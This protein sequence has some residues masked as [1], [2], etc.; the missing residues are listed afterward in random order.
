[1][2]QHQINH[3]DPSPTLLRLTPIPSQILTLFY[4]G[5]PF[6]I[7]LD[8]GATVS[9]IKNSYVQ[10]HSIPIKPNNQLALLADDKTR[11]ASLGEV[12]ISLTRGPITARLRALVMEN[13][14][15]DCFGGTTF[16]HDND[17]QPRIKSRQIKI[18][19]K[20]VL[21]QTNEQLPLPTQTTP[22]P[23][24]NQITLTTRPSHTFLKPPS[25]S[26]L[27]PDES[28]ALTYKDKL[29]PS[30]DFVT[31]QPLENL[32]QW[33]P[34]ICPVINRSV[35]YTNH[36]RRPL[37]SD[38]TSKFL[39][40][41]A[42]IPSP[43][44][45]IP[46]LSR[47]PP[48]IHRVSSELTKIIESNTNTSCLTESQRNL[49]RD[50]HL[51]NSVVF[52]S[53]LTEGYNGSAGKFFATLNFKTEQKPE[54]KICPIP[55][56]N[57]KCANL[58]QQVMD[59]LEKQGV[60]VDPLEHN[61][62]VTKLS[63]SF[64]LQKGRAKH[65]K[66]EDCTVDEIRWV[67]GFN[68]LN[69]DLLPRPSKPTSGRN[70]LTF[71]AKHRY[72]IHA[73]LFNSYFQIPV[74]K[75]D[76]QWL[77]VRTPFKGIRVLTRS[78]QGLLNSES[79]LD[80][81]IARVLGQ[82]LADGICYAER[83]DIIIGGE[84]IDDTITNWNRVLG[85]LKSANLKLSPSK[86]KI[87]PMDIEIFGLRIKDG[88]VLP[89]DHI[90]KSLG[91]SS[92][93][94]LKT[95]KNVNSWKGLYKTLLSSLPNLASVMDPFDKACAGK[96][97]RESFTWTDQLIAHFNNALSHLSNVSPLTLP[98]PNEQLILMPDGA[99]VPGGIGW[100]LFVQRVKDNKPILIPVQ[101]YS[102]KIKD[103]M[104]KWLPCE[105]EGVAS[106]MAIN[107]CSHWI[108]ASSKPTY[109]TPDCKA[110]VEA[111]ERM[112]QGKLSRNPR[113]QMILISINRRPVVF[114]HSSA[115]SGQHAIPDHASRLDITCGSKDCAVE[116]FLSELPENI[117]CM[118]LKPDSLS[119]LFNP[120]E[121]CVI[122]ATSSELIDLLANKDQLPLGDLNLWKQIQRSDP[123][124]R[125]VHNLLSTGDSPRKN[126]SRMIKSVFRHAS[127]QDDLLVVK[128]TDESLFKEFKR[129][130]IPKNRVFPVLSIIHLKG[131]HPSKF[132]TEKVFMRYFFCPGF[133]EKLDLFYDQ[134]FLCQSIKRTSAE[135]Q[136][137][138]VPDPPTHPG[139]R[140]N[141]D[142][143]KRSKQ[144]ILVNMD[145]FSNYL[146]A[147]LVNS[148]RSQD[149]QEGLIKI[150]SPIQLSPTVSVR[151][152][153]APALKSLASQENSLLSQAG[154]HLDVGEPLNKNSNCY[155][156]KAIQELELEISKTVQACD[157]IT[158]ADLAKATFN[159]NSKI[160]H[161][162]LTSRE[163]MFR[164]EDSTK[165]PVKVSDSQIRSHNLTRQMHQ[166]ALRKTTHQATQVIPGDIVFLKDNPQK[167]TRRSAFIVTG[168]TSD[169]VTVQKVLNLESQK[170]CNISNSA[171][172]V[173]RSRIFKSN[174]GMYTNLYQNP[175]KP[176]KPDIVEIWNPVSPANQDSDDDSV[177]DP[178][179]LSTTQSQFSPI[180]ESSREWH[181]CLHPSE[182]EDSS[183]PNS[184]ILSQPQSD[185]ELSPSLEPYLLQRQIFERQLMLSRIRSALSPDP[186]EALKNAESSARNAVISHQKTISSPTLPEGEN[187]YQTPDTSP[188][189][190]QLPPD[191]SPR[192]AKKD[193]RR[194]LAIL[195]KRIPQLDGGAST[196]TTNTTDTSY[197][198][199]HQDIP[200][201]HE[202]NQLLP[203]AYPVGLDPLNYDEPCTFFYTGLSC[204]NML[205]TDSLDIPITRIRLRSESVCDLS[206]HSTQA[207]RLRSLTDPHLLENTEN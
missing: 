171:H 19:N 48:P 107:A 11:M 151:V 54:S 26:P 195:Y 24:S 189:L 116:R 40:L 57:H 33:E 172:T 32:K 27:Y 174:Q 47:P 160:R 1:M 2:R 137:F 88:Q 56:Y 106:A 104:Q 183:L 4:N 109:V 157:K 117:Q 91:K 121:P 20:Y 53:D 37:M 181:Q 188:A 119:D 125:Q 180:R 35:I 166:H 17:V 51:Q 83:D 120:V 25:P 186:Y 165:A 89:S 149:L 74:R 108:L 22:S 184:P 6:H 28:V 145:I 82:E 92:I 187:S 132:Q 207:R 167:H 9:F 159:I 127:L 7:T 64:I 126:T 199:S 193:A 60:L 73:D 84:T 144:L 194:N 158:N 42:S 67:V 178:T 93:Q 162:G 197:S 8:T 99:R 30:E 16:H 85:K 71:L 118:G 205:D 124:L 103:Y 14:Q 50:I 169:H 21:Q 62:K 155:I 175:M 34:Q 148:E 94:E 122:A 97:S 95:V 5:A 46:D 190:Q 39:C 113:L 61:I 142:I 150:I 128:E 77:G 69:D 65:K 164:R 168:Q 179:E 202:S 41:P 18:L 90:I 134:C 75:K 58:Q 114:L 154:I 191:L 203:T 129:I 23:T 52:D 146:T 15:A 131:N 152:D 130:V 45:Q 170:R 63:P 140:M 135:L 206:L 204:P 163:I 38:K 177:A 176:H 3:H 192:P 55:L 133:R 79:E 138:R 49:L 43:T 111:V 200:P 110:V 96:G 102:A 68:S 141:A 115:K 98:Q 139:I 80:E 13:L 59:E 44:S 153:S 161:S 70:I 201:R 147:T 173:L 86:V 182:D 185:S 76:W 100:A 66:L 156:D 105:I 12:D 196:D 143:I 78:G 36:T 123:D 72:H 136:P 31:L 112:R 29:L 101:F 81:L 87:F 10:L 198:S